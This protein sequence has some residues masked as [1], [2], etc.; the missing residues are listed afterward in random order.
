MEDGGCTDEEPQQEAQA[1]L[2]RRRWAAPR[3]VD[4]GGLDLRGQEGR[5]GHMGDECGASLVDER[6]YLLSLFAAGLHLKDTTEKVMEDHCSNTFLV[7][8]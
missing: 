6:V 8:R 2:Q 1:W 7:S 4:G 5:E 3:R